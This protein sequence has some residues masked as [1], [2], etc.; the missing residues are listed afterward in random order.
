MAFARSFGKLGLCKDMVTSAV[1]G[2]TALKFHRK[3]NN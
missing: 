2:A 3:Q 1:F